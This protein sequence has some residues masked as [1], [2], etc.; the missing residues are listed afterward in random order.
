MAREAED[1][2]IALQEPAALG[3][4]EVAG[5]LVHSECL[6]YSAIPH[7][8]S[9]FQDHLYRFER[10]RRFYAEPPHSAEWIRE[11]SAIPYQPERRSRVADVLTRQARAFGAPPAVLANVE[12]PRR[13]ALAEG[14]RAQ[15]RLF[16]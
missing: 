8:T 1:T 13:G 3:P 16:W 4:R 12:R 6:P 9:I 14:A 10:V 5:P 2:Q 11:H 15:G 7:T